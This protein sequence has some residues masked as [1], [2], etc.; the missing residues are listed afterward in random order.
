MYK[1]KKKMDGFDYI[2]T[3]E[4]VTTYYLRFMLNIDRNFNV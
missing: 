3:D 2:F 1:K 4:R